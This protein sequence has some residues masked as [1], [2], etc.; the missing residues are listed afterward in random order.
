MKKTLESS[1]ESKEINQSILKEINP[2]YSSEELMLKAIWWQE[3][4][5]WKRPCCWERLKAEGEDGDRGW[6]GWMASP[7]QWTWTWANSRRWWGT[8]KSGVLGPWSPE[9]SNMTW[10]LNNSKQI[11]LA[12]IHCILKAP[13]SISKWG[14][15]WGGGMLKLESTGQPSQEF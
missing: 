3:L 5:H 15:R 13:E 14:G 2:E 7:I 11:C 12:N 10:W 4:T 1:M 6:D 8:G 9:K